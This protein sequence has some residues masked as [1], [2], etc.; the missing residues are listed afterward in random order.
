ME[1]VTT[2]YY[3]ECDVK[4]QHYLIHKDWT[5]VVRCSELGVKNARQQQTSHP[6]VE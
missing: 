3:S 1:V 2:T 4:C 6:D 5:V